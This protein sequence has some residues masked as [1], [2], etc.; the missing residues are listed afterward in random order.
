MSNKPINSMKD[1]EKFRRMTEQLRL[2]HTDEEVANYLRWILSAASP[3]RNYTRP[4]DPHH[5]DRPEDWL[6]STLIFSQALA[7][8]LEERTGV[9]VELR[10][11]AH[12][13][14][15]ESNRVVVYHR[16]GQVAI[17]DCQED[18]PAG[19]LLSIVDPSDN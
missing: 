18:L 19:T 9:V 17:D 15:G 14:M 1:T 11:D 5:V 10:G 12:N 7:L 2:T 6:N 3:G 8:L 4:N 13:P 16:E